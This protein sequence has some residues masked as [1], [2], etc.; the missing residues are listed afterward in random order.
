[1]RVGA[2]VE[3]TREEILWRG[4]K[5]GEDDPSECG[6]SG[7]QTQT[8][9]DAELGI[10]LT[11]PCR[12]LNTSVGWRRVWRRKR[13]RGANL[14]ILVVVELPQHAWQMHQ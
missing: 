3:L 1:M 9:S 4:R 14:L 7:L 12:K 5:P 8:G 10:H 11:I 2:A 6:T 13:P